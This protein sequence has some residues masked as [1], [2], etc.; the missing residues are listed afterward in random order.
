MNQALLSLVGDTTINESCSK[1]L[2]RIDELLWNRTLLRDAPTWDPYLRRMAGYGNAALDGALMPVDPLVEPD[3]S[4]MGDLANKGLMITAESVPQAKSFLRTP[5]QVWARM[6]SMIESDEIERGRPRQSDSVED[7]LHIGDLVPHEFI[8]E[9]LGA[10]VGIIQDQ[11]LPT[12]FIAA[13]A[14]AELATVRPFVRGSYLVAR[15]TPR[16]VLAARELDEHGWTI[17]EFGMHL[18][19]RASYVRALNAYRSGT[20]S[21]MREWIEWHNL[22]LVRGAHACDELTKTKSVPTN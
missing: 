20:L 12:L 16:L 6:H 9:R 7:P 19:G 13:I 18:L 14:H 17:P 5:L 15:V 3:S 4:P 22:A 1:A 8:E 21:G 10:L 11:Q 2:S